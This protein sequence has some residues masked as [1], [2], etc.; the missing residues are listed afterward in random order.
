MGKDISSQKGFFITLVFLLSVSLL[1]SYFDTGVAGNVVVKRPQE[2]L[3][4]PASNQQFNAQQQNSPQSQQ[5]TCPF[6][7]KCGIKVPQI[8]GTGSA[9]YTPTSDQTQNAQSLMAAVKIAYAQALEDCKKNKEKKTKESLEERRKCL[10]EKAALCAAQ[11]CSFINKGTQPP[12]DPKECEIPTTPDGEGF[13]CTLGYPDGVVCNL[14][15]TVNSAQPVDCKQ[16]NN[17]NPTL[18]VT[19]KAKDGSLGETLYACEKPSRT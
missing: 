1:A 6:E 4:M 17:R 3:T 7:G 10:A 5:P 9:P 2:F 15:L 8:T 13:G 19:C 16:T 18:A 11:E 12:D 14:Q